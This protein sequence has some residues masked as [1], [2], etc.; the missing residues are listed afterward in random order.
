MLPLTKLGNYTGNILVSGWDG[1]ENSIYVLD[2]GEKSSQYDQGFLLSTEFISEQ[3]P[4]LL[5]NIEDVQPEIPEI[6]V[7]VIPEQLPQ[8]PQPEEEVITELGEQRIPSVPKAL[9]PSVIE[10]EVLKEQPKSTP[11]KKVIRTLETPKML[12]KKR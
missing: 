8:L 3:L 6:Y 1:K 2:L 9:D 5:S 10:G 4:D 11:P 7:E 12:K